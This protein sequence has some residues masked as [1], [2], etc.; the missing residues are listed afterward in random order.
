MTAIPPRQNDLAQLIDAAHESRREPPRAHMG[1]SQLGH[2]CD[3]WL[4]LSFRWAV[5]PAFSGRILRLFRRGQN[6]EETVVSDLRAAGLDVQSTGKNQKTINLGCHI[7]GSLDGIVT[8]VPEAPK[9][10]HV[11]EIKTHSAKSFADLVKH[12]VEKSKPMHWAQMQVYMYGSGLDRA[13]YYAVNKDTDEIHTE[14]VRL[15]KSAAEAIIERGQRIATAD[16]MPE[17]CIG[18]APDWYLC[19]FCDAHSFCHGKE[20][21]QHGNCRTCAHSTAKSDSTWHC[22]RW[23]ATIPEDAQRKGC[24]SHIPHPHLVPYPMRSGANEWQAIVVIDG[25]DVPVG[26]GGFSGLEVIANPK[27]CAEA[28]AGVMMLR[29]KFDGRIEK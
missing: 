12:G 4:W 14:R 2:H 7:S 5:V 6:E 23:D 15:D 17:P 9:K 13:L 26:D 10:P 28:D 27:A 29:E 21:A 24:D 8:G 1:A 11:L 20:P 19:R 16:G 3:R 22:L 25:K 18:A